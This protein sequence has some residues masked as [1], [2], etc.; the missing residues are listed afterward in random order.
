MALQWSK[1]SFLRLSAVI[2]E[3]EVLKK[4]MIS[5]HT[6]GERKHYLQKVQQAKKGVNVTTDEEHTKLTEVIYK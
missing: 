6:N 1:Y 5:I 3:T 2:H 4:H